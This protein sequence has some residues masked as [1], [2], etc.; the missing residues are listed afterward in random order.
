MYVVPEIVLMLKPPYTLEF[1]VWLSDTQTTIE[2]PT[3]NAGEGADAIV[4]VTVPEPLR[5]MLVIAYG[6]HV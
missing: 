4:A 2:S 6:R 1:I 3:F 5:L